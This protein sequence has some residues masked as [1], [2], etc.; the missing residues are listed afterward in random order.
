MCKIME[1]MDKVNEEKRLLSKKI[2]EK[3]NEIHGLSIY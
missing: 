2:E 1:Q 3:T